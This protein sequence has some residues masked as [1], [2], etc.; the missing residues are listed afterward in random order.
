MKIK[1]QFFRK[2]KDKETKK[3]EIE[4]ENIVWGGKGIGRIKGKVYFVQRSVPGDRLLIKIVKEKKDYG[5]GEIEKIIF[6]SQERVSPICK[7]FRSCGGC[8][9]QMMNY[10]SQV[11]SKEKMAKEILRRWTNKARFNKL[12]PME[13]PFEYRHSGDF[14]CFFSNGKL[15]C[16]FYEKESHRIVD[17]ENCHL[18]SKE[19]NQKLKKIKK[20]LEN[21]Q[22]DFVKSFNLSCGEDEKE[23]VATFSVKDEQKEINQFLKL[24]DEANLSGVA[25]KDK[26]GKTILKNGECFLSYSI[27]K[28]EGLLERDIKF[29]IDA[30]SFSQSNF[31]MNAKLVEEALRLANLSSYENVLELFSGIGNFTMALALKCKE[32]V[33]VEKSETA[34]EDSKF[35]STLNSIY[36]IR[37][38]KG[39]VQ[40]Q[41]GKLISSSAKFDFVLLD[42]PRS[43]AFEVIE[44]IVSLNPK[45]VVYVSCNLPTLERDLR[46]FG[47]KGFFPQEFSFFDLFPQTYGIESVVLLRNENEK[48]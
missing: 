20:F 24:K 10:K 7:D 13:N 3:E 9:L 25:L 18:F 30:E 29:K 47:E 42:P 45:R 38:I 31:E 44:S 43:G 27:K 41:I 14:H 37:H 46:K 5:E 26:S 8:Q 36:N 11:D 4:I 23:F 48:N 22:F 34:V 12:V 17:F 1:R 2:E 35:N 6:P 15:L 19:F 33:A 16:G 40:E 28:R 39:D 21:C 32:V